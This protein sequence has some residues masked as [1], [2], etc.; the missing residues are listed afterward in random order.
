[1]ISLL[2]VVG[3][4]GTVFAYGV[5]SSGK[6]HTMHVR[7][8]IIPFYTWSN[9]WSL[10]SDFYSFGPNSSSRKMFPFLWSKLSSCAVH[11]C[12]WIIVR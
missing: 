3:S 6:T 7:F 11:E 2:V 9:W 5:T 8:F 4:A 12:L 10:G 1:M